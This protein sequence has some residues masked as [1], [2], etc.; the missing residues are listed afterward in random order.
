MEENEDEPPTNESVDLVNDNNQA[1]KEGCENNDENQIDNVLGESDDNMEGTVDSD[2]GGTEE[3][4]NVVPDEVGEEHEGP[5][6][7]AAN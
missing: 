1:V 3:A 5:E 2:S 7:E 6:G 4:A